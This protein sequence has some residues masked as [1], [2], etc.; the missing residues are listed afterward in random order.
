MARLVI[1][2]HWLIEGPFVTAGAEATPVV[3]TVFHRDAGGALCVGRSHVKGKLL[4]AAL[5]ICGAGGALEELVFWWFGRGDP[6]PQGERVYVSDLR[7]VRRTG[8]AQ[9]DW[10]RTDLD[11]RAPGEAARMPAVAPQFH[12]EDFRELAPNASDTIARTAIGGQGAAEAHTLRVAESQP[13]GLG[14]LWA[15][16]IEAEDPRTE[17]LKDLAALLQLSALRVESFGAFKGV[18]YGLVAADDGVC[19]EATVDGDVLSEEA[20]SQA[21]E[22]LSHAKAPKPV[23]PQPP[24]SNGT[25]SSQS[26]TGTG[27][28][29]DMPLLL[30]PLEPVYVLERKRP[31]SH[32]SS[33]PDWISGAVIKGAL[34]AALNRHAG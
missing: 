7:P 15:G 11:D 34:A 2:L 28:C 21:R 9:H 4:D 12:V 29:C 16:R 8:V 20:L 19:F 17:A 18:G 31:D 23:A 25:G 32:F 30:F 33:A 5:T 27:A 1:D 13:R 6:E 10:R 14:V 24:A 22:G 3:D 26:T